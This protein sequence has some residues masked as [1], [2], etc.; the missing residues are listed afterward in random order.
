MER[1]HLPS[2]IH[3]SRGLLEVKI[4]KT[5]PDV[6]TSIILYCGGGGRS[7]LAALSLQVM[8]YTHVQSMAGGFKAWVSSGDDACIVEPTS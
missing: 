7:A 5:I 2:A 6:N 8:G 3:L 1:G 4:E